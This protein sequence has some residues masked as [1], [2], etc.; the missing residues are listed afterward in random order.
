M[1][2]AAHQIGRFA[3][4]AAWGCLAWLAAA[5]GVLQQRLI[6]AD[7]F[8]GAI[9]GKASEGLAAAKAA[10]PDQE[11]VLRIET[12][13]HVA[14]I[15]RIGVDAQCRI[16]ATGSDD[17]T[18]RLW[19]LPDGKLLRVLRP[20]IGA[21]NNGKVFAVAISPDGRFVAAGGWDAHY[22]VDGKDAVSIFDAA[23][24]ALV[25]RVGTFEDAVD[26]LTFSGD[27]RWLAM[28]SGKRVGLRVFDATT[29]RE[30]AADND[31]GNDSYGAAFG[32]DGRLYTV[33]FD[34]E[35]RR[36]GPGPAFKREA[37]VETHGGK[38]PKFVT[39]T[40]KPSPG[41]AT[42]GPC[43]PGGVTF[44]GGRCPSY[45]ST[46][47]AAALATRRRRSWMPQSSASP[48]AATAS[49]SRRAILPSA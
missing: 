24:G 14:L 16:A 39:G 26:H 2:T 40:L 49:R 15:R 18:V 33:A 17:K 30:V 21:G 46:A 42:A 48:P 38:H 25:A 45:S 11:P 23:S 47:T 7:C 34:G 44:R 20:P 37:V 28:V 12:G 41:A 35:L 10:C 36:Y 3:R 4:Y 19:S 6:D 32:P 5:S 13:M 22:D 27:G 9:D 43:S 29:W 8:S 1:R 31:Y